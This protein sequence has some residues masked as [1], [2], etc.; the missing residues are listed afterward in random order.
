MPITTRNADAQDAG[1]PSEDFLR[2]ATELADPTVLRITLLQLT[3]DPKYERME[4]RTFSDRGGAYTGLALDEASTREV[5]EDMFR[6]LVSGRYRAAEKKPDDATLRRLIDTFIG[7]P[8]NDRQF[9]YY[10]EELAFEEAPFTAEWNG[11]RPRDAGERQVLVIG[12]GFS[13]VAVGVQLKRLGIPFTILERRHELGGT[14]SINRYPDARVDSNSFL[15]Q[16]K[17][18]KRFPWTEY[19]ARQPEVRAYL[20]HVARKFGVLEHI[21]FDASVDG[22]RYDEAAGKWRLKVTENGRPR[23]LEADFVVSATGLFSNPLPLAVKGAERFAGTLVHS[24]KWTDEVAVQ[25]KRVAIIGNG[26]TGVQMMARVAEAA[27]ELTVFQRTPQWITPTALYGD[28]IQPEVRWLLDQLPYYWNWFCFSRAVP[29]YSFASVQTIDDAWRA[30]GGQVSAKND[31]MRAALTA[32]IEAQVQGRRDLIEKLVPPYPPMARRL[33]IDN[34]WYRALLRPNVKLETT[35]IREITRN[36]VVTE[37][38]VEHPVDVIVSATGFSTTR[39]VHPAEYNGRGGRKLEDLWEAGGPRAYLG[40]CAPGF[41]NFF[42]MYGP[43]G[44][45]RSSGLIPFMEQWARYIARSICTVIEKGARSIEVTQDAYDRY[46]V[47]VDQASEEIVW[48]LA[49]RNYYMNEHGR[50]HVSAPWVAEHSYELLREPRLD[51]L[52]LAS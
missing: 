19:Y 18:E 3:G 20:E 5:R 30:K 16:Y 11:A 49:P 41:P 4:L 29:Y 12:A 50:Q 13:G 14:W 34:G 45:T 39:Y 9:N 22:G 36:G 8:V 26:S 23:D 40:V 42:M 51:D 17:F 35:P 27:R 24:T 47:A 32:Y 7:A 44:Q 10:K 6:L 38:G 52:K 2:R 25:G 31:A 46:N 15:Y 48:K 1:I 28:P 37:D 33:I 21:R 43:N